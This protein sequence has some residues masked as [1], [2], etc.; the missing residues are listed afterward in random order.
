MQRSGFLI[1]VATLLMA[2][3]ASAQTGGQ[4]CVRSF[5]DRNGNG[6]LDAGEPLLTSGISANLLNAEDVIV[7]S[8]LLA[9]SPTAAQGVVCFQ[10]LA[11]GN[12]SIAI[13]SPDY[14]PTTDS[15]FS[16]TIS[17]GTLPA[18]IA[19][20]GQRVAIDEPAV[21]SNTGAPTFEMDEQ[22]LQRIVL[23]LLGA[24]LVMAGMI[25]LGTLIYLLGLRDREPVIDPPQPVT[26]TGS[27]RTMEPVIDPGGDTDEIKTVT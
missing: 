2:T 27:I 24:L 9:D 20:G 15:T 26:T 22:L 5:E 13:T 17:E 7:A 19:F 16:T 8:A 6:V 11:P 12:Y 14:Q 3:V 23:S 21:D 4:F 1:L 18:V 25:V 10:F